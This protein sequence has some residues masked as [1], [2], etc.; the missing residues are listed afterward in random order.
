M[1]PIIFRLGFI[2]FGTALVL[3]G[4]GTATSA[5]VACANLKDTSV[6]PDGS[7]ADLDAGDLNVPVDDPGVSAP[8]PDTGTPPASGRVRLANLLSGPGAVS[9]CSKPTSP[10]T[11]PWESTGLTVGF[12]GV[13][14]P[15]F[16]TVAVAGNTGVPYQHRIV[17]SGSP[18]DGEGA[19]VYAQ[20]PSAGIALRQGG[21][22]TVSVV[23]IAR[24]GTDAGD[25]N[26]RVVATADNNAPPAVATLLRAV[27]GIPN[28]PAFDVVINGETI[29]TGVKYGTA[30]GFPYSL[31]DTTGFRQIPAGIPAG[32]T[33]LL[34]AGT[35]VRSFSVAERVRRGVAMTLFIG[36]T[37]ESPSVS[38]CSDRAPPAGESL[39][40]CTDLPSAQ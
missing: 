32:S 35:T 34:R 28:L 36:G 17:A 8:P 14:A 39:A 23:G 30:A 18:C 21:G 7:S 3:A 13:S 12:G 40:T 37:A 25:G 2:G 11:A 15:A 6:V 10:P 20:T 27:H 24:S 38:L 1:R 19:V 31:G 26:A 33:L 5:I 22:T 16:L 4:T 9:L 29:I